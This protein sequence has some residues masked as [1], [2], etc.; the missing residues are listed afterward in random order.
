VLFYLGPEIVAAIQ[1]A[2]KCAVK[3]RTDYRLLW[4]KGLT[5]IFASPALYSE[6]DHCSLQMRL[7]EIQLPK[8]L[9][10]QESE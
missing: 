10:F 8:A 3:K 5:R 4:F 7:V 2:L 6:S 1:G 9:T